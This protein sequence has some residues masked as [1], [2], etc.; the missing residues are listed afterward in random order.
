MIQI[1]SEHERITGMPNKSIRLPNFLIIGAPKAGT[2]SLYRY[3]AEHPKVF[4][5]PLKEPKFFAIEGQDVDYSGP[6]DD[7]HEYVTD[8]ETYLSLFDTATS[9]TA[10]G[11]AS[12][13]YLHMRGSAERIHTHIPNVKIVAILRDPVER[14]YSQFCMHKG[15]RHEPI[16]DFESA[17][18]A[19]AKRMSDNWSPRWFYRDRGFY[20]AQLRRYFDI[21][22]KEQ[23]RVYLFDDLERDSLAVVQDIYE[24][25]GVDSNFF[26]DTNQKFN[27]RPHRSSSGLYAALRWSDRIRSIATGLART[28]VGSRLARI[29]TKLDSQKRVSLATATRRRLI[30]EYRDDIVQLSGLIDRDLSHW[31]KT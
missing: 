15:Y 20:Y 8:Y 4:M 11:E 30:E 18:Q 17:W 28:P 9:E 2:T 16:S 26:P 1:P 13:W 12:P 7:T 27:M 25:L 23:I 29:G 31:L 21:F 22:D 3:L 19:E 24:F 5:S 10:L 6:G 14:A